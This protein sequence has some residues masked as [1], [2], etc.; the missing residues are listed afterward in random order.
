MKEKLSVLQELVNK[1]LDLDLFY[2]VSFDNCGTIS[3]QGKMNY[4]IIKTLGEKHG[5]VF[6][7]ETDS[8]FLRGNFEYNETNVRFVLS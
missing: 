2:H 3:L 7:N 8:G 4:D 5:V 1:G 6:Q